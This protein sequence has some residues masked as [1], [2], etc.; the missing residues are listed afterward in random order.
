VFELV[1][2]PQDAADRPRSGRGFAA[3]LAGVLG[4]VVGLLLA[5]FRAHTAF[6]PDSDCRTAAHG[7]CAH[8]AR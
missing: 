3:T 7:A 1:A 4:I 2:Q 5:L 6:A 8:A